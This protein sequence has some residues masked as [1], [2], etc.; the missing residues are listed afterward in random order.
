[1]TL[2]KA[3][4]KLFTCAASRAIILDLVVGL[5]AHSYIKCFRG[6][7]SPRRCTNFAI[8]DGGTS[9]VSMNL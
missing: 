3:L 9:F 1:M 5:D 4:V 8:L 2:N 7:L 6:F